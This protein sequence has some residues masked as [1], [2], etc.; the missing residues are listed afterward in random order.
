MPWCSI[1]GT[2]CLSG[3]N[4]VVGLSLNVLAWSMSPILTAGEGNFRQP[5][6]AIHFS[7]MAKTRCL[8]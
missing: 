7:K 5:G 1:A 3:L 8:T 2:L 6:C 4:Q